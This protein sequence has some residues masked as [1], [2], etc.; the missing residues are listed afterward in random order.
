MVGPLSLYK[1]SKGTIKG[2]NKPSLPTLV[3]ACI[4]EFGITFASWC[5]AS[6]AIPSNRDVHI[7]C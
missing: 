4:T 2:Q 5:L 1:P 7:S 6:Q 3:N